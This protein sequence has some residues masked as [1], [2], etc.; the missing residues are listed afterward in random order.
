MFRT[1]TLAL[2]AAVILVAALPTDPAAAAGDLEIAR[3]RHACAAAVTAAERRN[4]IPAQLLAAIS[5]AESGRWDADGGATIAWPWTVTAE[6]KGHFLPSRTA[7]IAKVRALRARG[8]RNIDVGCMQI[9]LHYHPDAFDDLPSA[10]DPATNAAYAG[11]F[12]AALERETGS[13]AAAAARYHSATRKYAQPYRAKVMKLWR[14]AQRDAPSAA[15]AQQE[16]NA[17]PAAAEPPDVIA[18]RQAATAHREA[19]IAAYLARR[20]ARQAEGATQLA[21]ATD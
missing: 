10:F 4:D 14:E 8:V 1:M 20:A 17:A 19:V 21:S 9:N 3:F 6:G 15:T 5:H 13:W 12:L 11:K 16:A 2:L 18:R 7:A